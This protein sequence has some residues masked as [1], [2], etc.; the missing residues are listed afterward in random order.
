[1]LI[2]EIGIV[3]NS[4]FLKQHRL[5]SRASPECTRWIKIAFQTKKLADQTKNSSIFDHLNLR[6]IYVKLNSRDCPI[7]IYN[8]S[9]SKMQFSRP[10]L[11]AVAFSTEYFGIDDN[12]FTIK[13]PDYKKLYP[14]FVIDVKNQKENMKGS[15]TDITV[16][17]YFDK[18][19]PINT[20][21]F[22]LV[23]SD[24][25]IKFQ[26]DGNKMAVVQN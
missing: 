14:I 17:S 24:K 21:A 26:S 12:C 4:L 16:E 11:D 6:S 8:L 22:A 3:V 13:P 25:M 20:E 2:L 19:V 18:N 9:F 7:E 5:S 10:Y 23:I 15:I 1:M